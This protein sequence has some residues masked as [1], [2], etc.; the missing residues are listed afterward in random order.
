MERVLTFS[1][2]HPIIIVCPHGADD[3]H[4]DIIAETCAQELNCFAV[5][6]KGF[7][8]AKEVNSLLDKADCNRLDHV[9][10][11]EVVRIEYWDPFLK[12]VT[13]ILLAYKE[14]WIFHIHGFGELVEK[15]TKDYIDIIL[16]YG[17]HPNRPSYTC[18]LRRRDQFIYNYRDLN[19]T[20]DV[21]VGKGGG[22]YAAHSSN[23][24]NQFFRKHM[25]EPTIESMQIEITRRI[26]QTPYDA[27]ITGKMLSKTIARMFHNHHNFYNSSTVVN[28]KEI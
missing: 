5:I 25:Q 27:I 12:Y 8:R 18:S 23:N 19:G 3:T 22:R 21:Y 6:N 20:G 1:G 13:S 17:E 15:R 26:R 10:D 9:T 4:T 28:Y 24:I 16:G 11:D 7:E 2:N 14:P